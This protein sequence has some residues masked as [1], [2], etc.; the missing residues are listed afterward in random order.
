MKKFYCNGARDFCDCTII[1]A[2]CG[3]ADGSGGEFRDMQV[4]DTRDEPHEIF[5]IP[6]PPDVGEKGGDAV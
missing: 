4:P 1:C 6:E 2:D 3:F 5:P